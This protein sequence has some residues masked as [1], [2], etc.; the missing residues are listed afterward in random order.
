MKLPSA[1][2]PSLLSLPAELRLHIYKHLLTPTQPVEL[3]I[4]YPD[5]HP[6]RTIYPAVLRTCKT[7]YAEAQAQLYEHNVFQIQL[8]SPDFLISTE[9]PLFIQNVSIPV[10]LP[11]G[12]DTKNRQ[13]ATRIEKRGVITP[14]MLRR[15]KHLEICAASYTFWSSRNGQDFVSEKGKVLMEIL[16]VIRDGEGGDCGDLRDEDRATLTVRIA[17]NNPSF[18]ARPIFPPFA[19]EAVGGWLSLEGNTCTDDIEKF[20][21]GV[22]EKRR[23][24]VDEYWNSHGKG[25]HPLDWGLFG[26]P[27][28]DCQLPLAPLPDE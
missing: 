9:I 4:D 3:Y 10:G 18:T 19:K 17:A 7:I 28:M 12:R 2:P 6:T 21:A 26:E 20:L 16:N 24:E 15:M 5:Y 8:V 11:L 22:K 23:F 27:L 14:H 13:Q 1:L 25:W